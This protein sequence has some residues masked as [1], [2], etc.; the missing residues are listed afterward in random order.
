V[1]DSQV[2]PLVVAV[3]AALGKKV[4][5]LRYLPS[6][7]A[8]ARALAGTGPAPELQL[9]YLEGDFSPDV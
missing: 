7:E 4:R 6:P 9:D 8:A 3:E 5:S 1:T 2:P